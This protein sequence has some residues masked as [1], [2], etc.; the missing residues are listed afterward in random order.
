VACESALK[1]DP[2]TDELQPIEIA[3]IFDTSAGSPCAPIVTRPKQ[4]KSQQ[5]QNVVSEREQSHVSKPIH[6]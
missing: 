1:H 6:I 5:I 3:Y 2:I 4:R